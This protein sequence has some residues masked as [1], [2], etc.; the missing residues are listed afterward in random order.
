MIIKSL[1]SKSDDYEICGE[2]GNGKEAVSQYKELK[3]DIV[4]LDI[5]MPE[6][7]GKE[8]LKA[9]LEIDPNAKVV[10]MTSEGKAEALEAVSL[11]AKSFVEKPATPENLIETL[12]GVG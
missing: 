4:T 11:G 7:N 9:I 8:A 2:A 5:N 6:M 10:M 3:P 1:T 12:G